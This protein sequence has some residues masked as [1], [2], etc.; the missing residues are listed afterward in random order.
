MS[1]NETNNAMDEVSHADALK[2]LL[3]DED[4]YD[5]TLKGTDGELVPAPRNIL[6][7]RSLLQRFDPVLVQ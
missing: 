7:A 1:S 5:V 3:T 2:L 4:L 6:A